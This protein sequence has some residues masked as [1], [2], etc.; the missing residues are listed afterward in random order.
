MPKHWINKLNESNSRKHKETTIQQAVA[1]EQ[2]G[3]DAARTFLTAAWYAYNPFHT[4]NIKQVPVTEGIEDAENPWG[5]FFE[6]LVDLADRRITGNAALDTVGAMS[7]RFDSDTW[8]LLC[9]PT[10]LKDLRVGATLKTFNKYLKDDFKIPVF[11]CQL[12]TDSKKHPKKLTGDQFL[13]RKLD[14]VRAI[15]IIQIT[16]EHVSV[17]MFS[18]NGKRFLNFGHVEEQ[19]ELV[20]QGIA[21]ATYQ[22]AFVLDGEVMSTDF[23][24]LMRQANRKHDADAEDSV[25]H[26]F[27]MVPLGS[28]RSGKSVIK[29]HTRLEQ[30]NSVKHLIEKHANIQVEPHLRVNL[31]LEEGHNQMKRYADD[32]V[33]QGFEG[34]MVKRADAPYQCK[35]STDW[36]KWKP[37]ITV[38]L[39]VIELEEGTGRNKGRLGALVCEGIDDGRKINVN[40]GSGLSDRDRDEFWNSKDSII[41]QVVEIQA[42]AVSQNQDGTYSLRFPRF[43]RFRGFEAGEKI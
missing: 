3:D 8:N 27:D 6:L 9:R 26:I 29:Q 37:V 43:E 5:Q 20:A 35:R 32:C 12:A 13:Q 34:I 11:E 17:Q 21:L 39:N 36:L 30:L 18:R 23:Q 19:L 4:Y 33:A 41:G 28:F 10:I 2:L 16:S 42:D 25:Y 15:T 22:S 14:G 1:S 40:V 24:S 38:D 31:N 7:E